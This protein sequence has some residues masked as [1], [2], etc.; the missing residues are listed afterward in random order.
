[1]D[2]SGSDKIMLEKMPS[3]WPAIPRIFCRDR[4]LRIG[5]RAIH[6]RRVASRRR[7]TIFFWIYLSQAVAGSVAGFIVPF[8]YFFGLL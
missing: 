6:W 3:A 7:L 8:L 1:V 4:E 2:T 5:A